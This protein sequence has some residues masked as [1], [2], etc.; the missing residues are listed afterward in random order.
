L[1]I[2]I[3]VR[4]DIPSYEFQ[5][6]LEGTPYRLAFRYNRRRERWAMDIQSQQGVMLLAG[7]PILV[8]MDLTSRFRVVDGPPG[9]FF[10]VD[11]SNQDLPPTEA[12]LGNR[13]LLYYEEAANG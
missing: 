3:P 6:T 9:R 10:A 7:V 2:Q 5:I 11:S 8:A 1:I 12:D 4:S 13:V